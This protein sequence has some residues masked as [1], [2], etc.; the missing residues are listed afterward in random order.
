MQAQGALYGRAEPGATLA[1][2]YRVIRFDLRQ[3]YRH[4]DRVNISK[5]QRSDPF[6]YEPSASNPFSQAYDGINFNGNISRSIG[7]GNNQDLVVNSNLNLQLAGTLNN[8]IDLL[9]AIS[10]ENNP[11]QPEGNTQQLQDFDRV[12]IQ[13]S[14]GPHKLTVG[15]FEN[16]TSCRKLFPE[17]L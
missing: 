8:D 1:V 11:I 15:D 9:A 14:K 17:L 6:K 12:F 3:V 13:L 4:K 2:T 5:A 16:D 10:D 7:F